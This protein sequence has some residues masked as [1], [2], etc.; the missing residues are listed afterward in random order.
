MIKAVFFDFDGVLTRDKT[1]SLTTTRY[2]S[3]KTGIGYEQIRD[4]FKK[5]NNDL[6]LGRTTH[7]EIWP[8]V[9]RE[10]RRKIDI[11]LLRE[12]FESTPMNN[13]MFRLARSLKEHYS[14]GIITDNKKDR[15][16]HLKRYVGLPSVFDPI[17]VS[18]DI[19]S[20][21]ENTLIFERALKQLGIAA[22]ESVFVDNTRDNLVA[23]DTLGMKTVYFDDEKNDLQELVTTLKEKHGL[24]ITS[25]A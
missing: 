25:A 20:G 18:A 8:N 2:L 5:Y 24:S 6:N 11:V 15:I 16:E 9:C 12:A 3:Q 14:V 7:E 19:G 13:G 1:G 22:S 21:K 4:A 10:L 23:P 17:V